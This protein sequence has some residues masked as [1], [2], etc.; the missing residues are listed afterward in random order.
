MTVSI[1][2]SH[3]IL[4]ARLATR[5]AKP[6]GSFHLLP[7]DVPS[8]LAPLDITD[9]HGF[10]R[11]AKLKALEKLG[12]IKLGELGKKSRAQLVEA[13]GKVMGERVYGAVRGVDGRG[14]ESDKP[15]KSVSCEINVS[16]SFPPLLVID[17]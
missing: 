11:Q 1:G 9:L 7:Q 3:N 5:R 14:L 15:R 2:I 10:G 17:N 16:F 6:G 8:F 13:L 12:T 4:L